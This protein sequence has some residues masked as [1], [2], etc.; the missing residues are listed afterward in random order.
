MN[1]RHVK[2]IDSTIGFLGV[3]LLSCPI[4]CTSISNIFTILIIRPG[5]IGDAILLAPTIISIKKLYPQARLTILAERRNARAFSL[6]SGV[7]EVLC[8]DLPHDFFKALRGRY[9]VVIDTEQWHRL[10]A[11]VARLVR[12]PLKIGFDTNE[13]RRMFTHSIRYDLEEYEPENFASLL[14]PLGVDCQRDVGDDSL[15]LP[16]KAVFRASQLLQPLNS[17]S[18]VVFFP[19]ASI[20][21]KRWGPERFSLVTK[22]LA[23]DGIRVVL[24]GGRDER[25]VG[26]VIAEAGGLSLAGLTSL[27]ETAA[28]IDKS[29]LLVSGDSGV[30]HIAAGLGKPTVSI[31]GP[32]SV[33]KWAPRGEKHLVIS[34]NLNCSP[35]TKFGYTPKCSIKAKCM[36]DIT[37]DEVVAAIEDLLGDNR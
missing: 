3:Y 12:A 33:K 23:G 13:R 29:S 31:F 30:L 20:E 27:A 16:A 19:G 9:D 34:K 1:I 22:Q 32:S 36:A 5:G 8:Y 24:V 7:D 14:T 28:I 2:M 26:D 10:S 15:S 25:S 35:C 37:V 21:E 6:V 18:F 11:V 4:P 17:D